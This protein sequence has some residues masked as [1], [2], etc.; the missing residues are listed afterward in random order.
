MVSVYRVLVI[1]LLLVVLGVALAVVT[2]CPKA[3]SFEEIRDEKG[4]AAAPPPPPPPPDSA[5]EDQPAYTPPTAPPVPEPAE[6]T[7]G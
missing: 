5:G 1:S 6:P 3:K 7:G 2:G 4:G